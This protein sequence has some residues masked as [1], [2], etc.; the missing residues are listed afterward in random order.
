MRPGCAQELEAP[1]VAALLSTRDAAALERNAGE[2]YVRE[3]A[4][5]RWCPA[6][7]CGRA[8]RVG[9]LGARDVR[10]G[11]CAH[12][13]CFRCARDAHAP[14]TCEQAAEWAD[15]LMRAQRGEWSG[16]EHGAVGT[17]E[18]LRAHA[19]ACPS[20]AAPIERAGGC[21]H[22]ACARCGHEF[23]WRCLERWRGHCGCAPA[24]LPLAPPRMRPGAR[25]AEAL[26]YCLAQSIAHA[27]AEAEVGALRAAARRQTATAVV[28]RHGAGGGPGGA[29]FA[30][31]A[32][33]APARETDAAPRATEQHDAQLDG[34]AAAL[35]ECRRALKASCMRAYF[36]EA[37]S[38]SD[39][40]EH[41]RAQLEETVARLTAALARAEPSEAG[42]LVAQTA[43]ACAQLRRLNAAMADEHPLVSGP[44]V[45]GGSAGE[46]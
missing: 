6:P 7:D 19:R 24:A 46:H 26:A 18:W 39:L 35:M 15:A 41:L 1:A 11:R 31:T 40:F 20:C 38:A 37:G 3:H 34:A 16:D 8:V 22:I 42:A 12:A 4:H 44:A 27:R 13:F 10:C 5:L 21:D 17:A 9:S 45:A 2:R 30:G 36:H 32:G 29:L 14:L 28:V 23:C 25:G 43:Q 33:G